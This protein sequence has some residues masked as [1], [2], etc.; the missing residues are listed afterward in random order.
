M[1]ARQIVNK[2]LHPLNL[3]EKVSAIK[4]LK[5][6]DFFY[7]QTISVNGLLHQGFIEKVSLKEIHR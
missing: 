4:G 6:D 5:D 1:K 3:Q 2:M 7:N